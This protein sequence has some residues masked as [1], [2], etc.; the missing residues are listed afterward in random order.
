[1]VG[2]EAD[3]G[4]PPFGTHQDD[5]HEDHHRRSPRTVLAKPLLVLPVYT[6]QG[7]SHTIQRS[8]SNQCNDQY[9]HKPQPRPLP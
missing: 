1:M 2:Y 4:Y 5:L 6:L 9:D 7:I 8:S 3:C